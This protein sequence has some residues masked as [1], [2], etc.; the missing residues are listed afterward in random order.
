M[1]EHW[2]NILRRARKVFPNNEISGKDGYSNGNDG[3]SKF[4][5]MFKKEDIDFC[6]TCLDMR[7]FLKIDR[8]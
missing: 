6:L 5:R 1:A 3:N 2:R 4:A 8:I 7:G